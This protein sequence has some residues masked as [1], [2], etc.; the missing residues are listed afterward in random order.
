MTIE[1]TLI[2]QT[3]LQPD[4]M[5]VR[6]E[7]QAS[8][9]IAFAY[10]D[11]SGRFAFRNVPLQADGVYFLVAEIDG[12]RP[13][14]ERLDRQ[15]DLRFGGHVTI[16]LDPETPSPPGD[17]SRESLVVDVR[18]LSAVIPSE[19]VDEYEKATS[20]SAKGNVEKSLEHLLRALERAPDYAEA[21]NHLGRQ[22]LALGRTDEA[23]TAFEQA[24]NLN[25]PWVIPVV[26]LGTL[27]YQEG[28]ARAAEGN[29]EEAAHMFAQ[30]VET[31]ESAIRVDPLSPTA[32][33][34][35]GASLAKTADLERA[36]TM[37]DR[38]LDLNPGLEDALL[39]L[40]NVYSRQG[41]YRE[42]ADAID[43]YLEREPDGPQAESLHRVRSQLESIL[44]A[45]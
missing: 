15:F 14:R 4:Q 35:L 22:Y 36:E 37:L 10:T 21:H 1:G 24:R 12:F 38:A 8:Q 29:A 44:A 7:G 33:Y 40:I 19:A 20:E 45:R 30:A 16:I 9:R 26:N 28:E 13:Y 39:P 25:P 32:H 11:G 17:A 6:L 23:K 41:R 27:Y 34:L 18:Q 42:A 5:E 31:L 2:V 3:P 43:R